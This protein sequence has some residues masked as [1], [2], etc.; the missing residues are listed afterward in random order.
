MTES[1]NFVSGTDGVPDGGTLQQ[2]ALVRE[3]ESLPTSEQT[4]VLLGLVRENA[5][6]V[7]RQTR[8]DTARTVD[9][10]RA[11]RE[12]GLDSVALVALHARLVAATGLPCPLPSPSTTPHRQPSPHICAPRP[13]D[14]PTCPIR[15]SRRASPPTTRS[16]SSA[17]AAATP[18]TC[19][20]PRT[21]GSW[22]PTAPTSATTSP[23]T[24]AGTSTG[25]S[26]TTPRPPAPPTP[27]T[28]DSCPVRPSSTRTS[29]P[30]AP[31]K[32]SRWTRSSASCW[33]PCGRP[34]SGPGSTRGPCAPAGPASSS[35]PSRR[36][37]RCACTRHRTAWTDTCSA[38]TPPAWSPAG[39]PTR[40][41]W[42]APR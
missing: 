42:R 28:A 26:T 35:P 25:S 22:S 3:L 13:W 7:L 19:R 17:S 6:A 10:A 32:P 21:C 41:A 24:G 34:W 38:A 36:S 2:A 27:G 8:P 18:V 11:F 5:V 1:E 40:S 12:L 15:S 31:V 14:C 33:R 20:P 4:R 37:T 23:P 9:P 30:S 16:P 29:S 39:S